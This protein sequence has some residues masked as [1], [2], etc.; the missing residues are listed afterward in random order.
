[1]KTIQINH[2]PATFSFKVRK[3][4]PEFQFNCPVRNKILLYQ[5]KKQRIDSPCHS[6]EDYGV[7]IVI[8]TET[9][10]IWE[11]GS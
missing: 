4:L 9:G 1:M 5:L 2:Y 7:D 8:P 11:L 6:Y 3:D 10:E